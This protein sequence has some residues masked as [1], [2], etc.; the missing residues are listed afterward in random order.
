MSLECCIGFGKL[1]QYEDSS[2]SSWKLKDKFISVAKLFKIHAF[3]ERP[4][5]KFIEMYIVGGEKNESV[6]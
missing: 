5:K 4:S 3:N 2:D 1:E 6:H